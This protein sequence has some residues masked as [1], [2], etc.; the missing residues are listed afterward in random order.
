MERPWPNPWASSRRLH[1]ALRDPL[2]GL[3][4][5]CVRGQDLWVERPHLELLRREL[6]VVPRH[7]GPSLRRVHGVGEEPV[8]HVPELVEERDSL[9]DG[10]QRRATRRR[11]RHVE[12][13]RG[14]GVQPGEPR[15]G[16]EFV[17]P[18]LRPPCP[19]GHTGRRGRIPGGVFRRVLRT[20]ADVLVPSRQVR[21]RGE[22]EAEEGP[23]RRE[24]AVDEHPLELEVGRGLRG[25]QLERLGAVALPQVGDIRALQRLRFIH[26]E[27]FADPPRFAGELLERGADER[28]QQSARGLDV[29]G[30]LV[31]DGVLGVA[32]EA[33]VSCQRGPQRR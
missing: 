33:Q 12:A 14:D 13:E 22:G 25:V 23:R 4:V 8:E 27:V 6:D 21:P 7:G 32:V 24:D 29:R 16:D 30:D 5:E 20:P 31:I 3:P 17:H 1:E 18:W 19:R 10:Q 11:L 2:V 28:P 15:A 9:V 26:P